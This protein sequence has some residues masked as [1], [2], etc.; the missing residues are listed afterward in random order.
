MSP[1]S[2]ASVDSDVN[3]AKAPVDIEVQPA[4]DSST[5]DVATAGGAPVEKVVEFL[6]FRKM[7][8]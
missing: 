4:L 2:P 5:I 1:G 7:V 6:S 3:I 8:I